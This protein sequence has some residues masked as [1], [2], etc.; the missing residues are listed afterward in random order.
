MLVI[1]AWK[2]KFHARNQQINI[3]ALTEKQESEK[4]EHQV[5]READ[6]VTI[7]D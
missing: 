1:D 4:S 3:D 7:A 5:D 2:Q 6:I